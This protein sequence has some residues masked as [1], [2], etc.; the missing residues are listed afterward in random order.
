MTGPTPSARDGA[1]DQLPPAPEICIAICTLDRPLELARTLSA[2]ARIDLSCVSEILVIDQS[3]HP[4]R[5]GC[6]REKLPV[7]LSVVHHRARGLGVGRNEALHRARSE[8]VLFLDDDVIPEHDLLT[9]HLDVYRRR[10]AAVGVAGYEALP[11]AW[12]EQPAV[13]FRSFVRRIVTPLLV[14]DD[15]YRRYLDARGEPV[16]V[17]TPSGLFLCDFARDQECR[18][19]TPRGC[20]MSWRRSVLLSLGGFDPGAVG[21]RRDESDMALRVIAASPDAEI[22]FEPRARVVHLMHPRGGCRSLSRR[23]SLAAL[24]RS[25]ARFARRH[26]LARGRWL[27]LARLAAVHSP[28][29]VR[30]PGLIRALLAAER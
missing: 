10:P 25:E 9:A 23:A 2:L 24:L 28:G 4:F 29:L 1:T 3:A 27:C 21:P 8:I 12:R 18:V 6:L 22:W 7:P 20:N 30:F 14:R 5:P 16:A 11:R 13:R 26:L 17:I 19:M 15:G